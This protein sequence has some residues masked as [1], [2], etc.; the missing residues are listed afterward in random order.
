M[1]RFRKIDAEA[2][3]YLPAS[4]AHPAD[5]YFHFSFADYHDP[6]RMNFGVLRVLND[7]DVRPK[8]GFGRHPHRN[9]EIVSYVVSG[10]L[11]HWD[12]VTDVEDTLRRGEAQAIS[13]GTGVW[14]SE[15]NDGDEACRFLQI[16]ILPSAVDLPVHYAA[17]KP[18]AEERRNRLLRLV[19]PRSDANGVPLQVNQDVNVYV[20]ELTDSSV[21]V[22]FSVKAGRQAYV[23]NFEGSVTI[24]GV[25]TLGERDTLEV[26]GPLELEFSGARAHFVLIEMPEP[27]PT[28]AGTTS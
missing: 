18:V 7:D 19:G 21:R 27:V 3:H 8:S 24:A 13:A 11:T 20:S 22:T 4:R 25:T 23:N 14:H 28:G 16:W 9:M 17:H 1:T 12:S 5:T 2:L 15:M 10:G 6:A 26:V